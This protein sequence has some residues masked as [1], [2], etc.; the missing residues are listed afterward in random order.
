MRSTLANVRFNLIQ[1]TFTSIRRWLMP[2][3]KKVTSTKRSHFMKK[4]R[5]QRIFPAP[6]LELLTP[7]W[8]GE[9]DEALSCLERAFEEHSGSFYS[10]L[11]RPE[12]RALRSDPR[13]ADLLRRIGIDFAKVPNRQ[14]NP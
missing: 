5:R 8:V 12:F 13:F 10:Y 9:K 14:K 4:P 3:A 1:T 7:S 2:T 6:G 11:F